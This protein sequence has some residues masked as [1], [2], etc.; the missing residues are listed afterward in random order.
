M[1]LD[2]YKR[3]LQEARREILASLDREADTAATDAAALV[4]NRVVGSG[5]RADGGRFSPYST[6]KA[7]AYLY[8]GRSVNQSGEAAVRR[9]ARL[10]QGVSY[11]DFRIF[12]GRGVSFKNFQF[13]GRM[14]QGFGV[15][16][17]Q[18]VRKAV[19]RI[20]LGGK[21]QYT[22]TLLAQHSAREGVNIVEVSDQEK[23]QVIKAVSDRIAAIIKKHLI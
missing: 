2:E 12:N 5:K 22:K 7:P 21:N 23:N 11:R 4:E 8:F 19:Y 17:V 15:V 16:S 3:K 9:Q 20:T 1:T 14:W 13:T 18:E 10:R 6:K